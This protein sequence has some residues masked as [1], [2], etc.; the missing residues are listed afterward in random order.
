MEPGGAVAS[1]DAG[2]A[3]SEVPEDDLGVRDL[4]R[5]LKPEPPRPASTNPITAECAICL[6]GKSPIQ[7]S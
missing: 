7:T 6:D 2:P 3:R 4:D 1:S 5:E